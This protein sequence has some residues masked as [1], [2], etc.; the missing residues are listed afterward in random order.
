MVSQASTPAG[1]RYFTRRTFQNNVTGES[2]EILKT[3]A[4]TDGEYIECIVTVPA[5]FKPLSLHSHPKQS[6]DF[7]ILTGQM[8]VKLDGRS[9]VASEGET[10]LVPARCVHTWWNAGDTELRFW[11]KVTPALHLC[12]LIASLYDAA[13][14]RNNAEPGLRDAIYVLEKYKDEYE[15]HFLPRPVINILFPIL[16]AAGKV[17]GRH[18]IMDQRIAANYD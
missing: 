3:P 11:S 4:D 16:Y 17:T 7:K 2:F 6:E 13:N 12:E 18:Q 15:P 5:G 1:V 8:G 14:A 10:L 9:L